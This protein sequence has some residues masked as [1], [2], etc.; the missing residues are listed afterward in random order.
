VTITATSTASGTALPVRSVKATVT[1]VPVIQVN[2]VPYAPSQMQVSSELNNVITSAPVGLMA[3]VTNDTTNAGVDWSACGS[4]RTAQGSCGNPGACG[5][6]QVSPAMAATS[7]TSAVNAVCSATIHTANGQAAFYVPPSQSPSPGGTVTITAKAHN[8]AATSSLA[9]ATAPVTIV[10]SPSGIALNGT[11]MAGANPVSGAT[12]SLYAAGTSGYGLQQSELTQATS[13]TNGAF[14][15]PAGYT[16]LS[17]SQM[18]LVA[19]GGG[20][21]GVSNNP[22]LALMTALGPCGSLSSTANI[23]INEVTTIGSIWP[24]APFMTATNVP[25]AYAYVGSSSTNATGLANAFAAVN[26]LVNV[27]TGQALATTPA[28]NGVVPQ[29]EINTLADILNTCSITAGG[30]V[31][32]GNSCAALFSATNP[33]A[34]NSYAPSNTLQAALNIAQASSSRYLEAIGATAYS[35]LPNNGFVPFT[36][37]LAAAPNDWSMSIYF[38]GG[39]LG[40]TTSTSADAS[41]LAI[42]GAGNIWT[43]NTG[44]NSVTE[45]NNLG[46]A[47]SPFPATPALAGGY[48]GGG[49][50]IP[51]AIAIDPLGNAWVANGN[52]TLTA[53]S[54]I[55][56]AISPSAGFSGGGLNDSVAGLAIDGYGN[57]WTANGAGSVSWF[58]GANATI[59]GVPKTP[60]TP[61]SSSSGFT[62]G[63]DSPNGAIEVDDSG[64]VWVMDSGNSSGIASAV[65][66]NSSTGSFLQSDYGYASVSPTPYD[67][68]L[69]QGAI[70]SG[71]AIDNAGDVLVTSAGQQLAEL[72]TGGSSKNAGGLGQILGSQT[73]GYFGFLALD[74]A[75]HIWLQ[76]SDFVLELSSGG[77]ALNTNSLGIGYL[78]PNINPND[79]AIA[80]DGSGDVWVL[81]SDGVTEFVGVAAPVVTPFSAGVQCAVSPTPN[82][83]KL[84]QEP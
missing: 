78:A 39:G 74:G 82:C 34:N 25:N 50:K 79:T 70:G 10:A 59:N 60:G 73:Q 6:F 80:V 15:I 32:Q 41:A 11:V 53:L 75:G 28:G 64:T 30:A 40:G 44:I 18:Y 31:G 21:S 22:N 27:E 63:F 8:P 19:I 43:A 29:S 47:L 38:S 9:T 35:L 33:G 14:T 45:L 56:S 77:T 23:T 36:P 5:L 42:D 49:L 26:N 24:L 68:V 51:L 76:Y 37:I 65:E 62:Q 2:F 46:A 17:E 48:K 13:G 52:G 58:A 54:P 61:L 55:G 4:I 81:N 67:S 66:L 84:S 20:V 16:C 57:V 1:V 3:A 12:V 72:L 69:N 71:I 83:R 7:T